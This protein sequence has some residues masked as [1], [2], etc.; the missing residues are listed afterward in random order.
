MA[1]FA[2]VVGYELPNN[3]AE[4]SFDLLPLF[5]DKIGSGPRKT[6]IHNTYADK[7]A[8][9]DGNWLLVDTSSGYSRKKI[10][11]PWEGKRGYEG[12][13]DQGAFLYNLKR[14]I[15]QKVNLLDTNP[16]KAKSLKA[17]LDKIRKQG[18]S[19]PRLE[20]R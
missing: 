4:D 1:T 18:H 19:A 3:Q 8:I 7:Y 9:R 16:E 12:E 11:E 2:S 17:L 6:H 14:D 15:G 20:S 10:H 13:G 5:T